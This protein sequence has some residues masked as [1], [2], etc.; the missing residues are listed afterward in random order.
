MLRAKQDGPGRLAALGY[1]AQKVNFHGHTVVDCCYR[2]FDGVDRWHVLDVSDGG[3]VLDRSNR[4]LLTLDELTHTYFTDWMFG[5]LHGRHQDMPAHRVEL[6]FRPGES[7]Q[8]A[9]SNWG[10]PYEDNVGRPAQ[11]VA[12]EGA[13][14]KEIEEHGP[15]P[16]AYG[17]GRWTYQPDLSRPDW[18]N[19]LA[20]EPDGLAKGK[21]MPAEAGKPASAVWR[22]RTPYI[23][24][25]AEV[26]LKLARASA[27][28]TV[29]LH[30]S[31]DD[32]AAWKLL[33]ECPA[34]VVGQQDLLVPICEKFTLTG[35]GKKRKFTPPAG[36]N[37]PFGATT[38]A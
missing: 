33:W 27:A 13:A 9:W 36:F 28:D 8:R 4:R 35:T 32:G 15:Y 3:F 10:R 38:T 18:T 20:A 25:D 23:V 17:N 24:S 12:S 2:D 1:P 5:W 37:S 30:L 22:F 16:Y 14:A 6:A 11:H 21:L 26:R 31:V 29:R 19:G 7:L 34:G